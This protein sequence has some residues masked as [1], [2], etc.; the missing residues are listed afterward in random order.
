M[1]PGETV[2]WGLEA[3]LTT[4]WLSFSVL[5]AANTR[6]LTRFV[7]ELSQDL[8]FVC[9]FAIVLLW[10]WKLRNDPEDQLADRILD[11]LTVYCSV[12][13]FAYGAYQLAPYRSFT[14]NVA[15]MMTV[16]LPLGYGFALVS[17]EQP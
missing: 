17:R 8:F 9:C 10:G 14:N 16:W 1:S 6:M 3:F 2:L 15:P 7:L 13:I 4:A 12:F 5:S 11:V